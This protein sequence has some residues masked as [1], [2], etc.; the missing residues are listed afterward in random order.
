MH[1]NDIAVEAEL[2]GISD[3][4]SNHRL[5]QPLHLAQNV[6]KY[7]TVQDF[8]PDF[9]MVDPHT[10]W[11]DDTYQ[12]SPTKNSIR[13]VKK[14]VETWSWDNFKP[15]IVT[16][17]ND[18]L[19]VVDGQH[20]SIAAA[21][22]PDIKRIPVFV[23]GIDQVSDAAKAFIAHNMNRTAVNPIQLFKASIEAGDDEAISINMALQR[24]NVKLSYGANLEERIGHCACLGT[25]KSVF[26]K[27]GM[28][29]LRITLDICV[30][31]KLAPIQAHYVVAISELMFAK[32]H[33]SKYDPQGIALAIRDYPYNKLVADIESQ[34][35]LN[36]EHRQ[37]TA[38]RMIKNKYESM[39]G[40]V[41]ASTT[42]SE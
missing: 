27:Y 10:L 19:F 38:V 21:T 22:H 29:N 26:N 11:V 35:R 3:A 20:T 32:E 7:S 39:F 17:Y 14:I 36:K 28:M 42:N 41:D 12:R 18:C 9:R 30:A 31:S 15:P 16:E 2:G 40:T 33:K 23:I 34:S 13:L 4:L 6:L 25:L 8:E 24:A 1:D 5:I 37:V